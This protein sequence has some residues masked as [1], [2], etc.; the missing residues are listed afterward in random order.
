[1]VSQCEEELKYYGFKSDINMRSVFVWDLKLILN[2]DFV[3]LVLKLSLKSL[4]IFSIRVW[5]LTEIKSFIFNIYF[6]SILIDKHTSHPLFVLDPI[7]DN[8]NRNR[9]PVLWM[10]FRIFMFFRNLLKRWLFFA[11]SLLFFYEFC[12]LFETFFQSFCIWLLCLKNEFI[13]RLFAVK[14]FF[15]RFVWKSFLWINDNIFYTRILTK[16]IPFHAYYYWRKMF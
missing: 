12:L 16:G 1:M 5:S 4:T 9:M 11:F 15:S 8:N 3:W 13:N 2:A 10:I 14:T 6:H 7:S